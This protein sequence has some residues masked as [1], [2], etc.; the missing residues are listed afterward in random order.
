MRVLFANVLLLRYC[1]SMANT[2]SAKK[3][4]RVSARKQVINLRHLRRVRSLMK[5][6]VVKHRGGDHEGARTQF[7]EAQQAIDKAAKRGVIKPRTASRRKAML[8]RAIKPVA[9]ESE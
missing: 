8:V 1:I 5:Q 9:A 6:V 3:A 2:T 4:I 7:R